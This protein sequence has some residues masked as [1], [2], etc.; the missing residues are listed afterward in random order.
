MEDNFPRSLVAGGHNVYTWVHIVRIL[1]PDG[2]NNMLDRGVLIVGVDNSMSDR[3]QSILRFFGEEVVYILFHGNA[4]DQHEHIPQH[5]VLQL[6][7]FRVVLAL[8]LDTS[9]NSHHETSADSHLKSYHH[10]SVIFC[11]L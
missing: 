6:Q 3:G 5:L 10:S 8:Q 4:M 9:G 2:D 1:I 7:C 11:I